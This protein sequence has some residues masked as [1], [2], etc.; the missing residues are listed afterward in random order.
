MSAPDL[1]WDERPEPSRL[2]EEW[3]LDMTLCIAAIAKKDNKVLLATDG[4]LSL[5]YMSF[6]SPMLKAMP[7]TAKKQFTLAF[8][9]SP[10]H[11]Q[12]V[13]FHALT[14][15]EGKEEAF[16]FVMEVCEQA[17]RTELTRKIEGQVLSPFGYDRPTFLKEGRHDLGDEEFG[18]LV[19]EIK[20]TRLDTTIMVCGFD[21]SGTPRVFSISDPG[22]ATSHDAAGF[23]AI[24][25]GT[26]S[27]LGA[28]YAHYD[29]N[30]TWVDLAYRMCEAKFLGESALGVGKNTAMLLMEPDGSARI[31]PLRPIEQI[32]DVWREFGRPPVPE[33]G[34]E[35][36]RRGFQFKVKPGDREGAK[37]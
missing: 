19:Y 16:P 1:W 6:D 25:S 37:P 26:F 30:G 31:M 9:G 33:Q 14:L 34:R 15:L 21:V 36:V 18:R 28:L 32:R 20:E 22:V 8:A 29:P 11:A 13:D 17:F 5:E 24:G 35:F 3:R 27:A 10:H 12:A 23:H 2:P 4:M 7:L